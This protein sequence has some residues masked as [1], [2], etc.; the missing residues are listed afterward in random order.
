MDTKGIEYSGAAPWL[1]VTSIHKVGFVHARICELALPKR[2][3]KTIRWEPF[4]QAEEILR[5]K[6]MLLCYQM[7]TGR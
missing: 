1:S 4:F 7:T 5:T 2:P 6:K 3:Y